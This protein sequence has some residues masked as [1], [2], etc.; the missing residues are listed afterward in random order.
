MSDPVERRGVV[1]GFAAYVLWGLAPLYFPLLEPAGAIEIL[2]HRILWSLVMVG[3]VVSA[4]KR[5]AW[6]RTLGMRK[7]VLLTLAAIAVSVN[8]G[9]YIYAVNEQRVIEVSL[10]Y[11]ILPL[12]YVMS[13]VA[14]YGERPRPA[15]WTGVALGVVAVAILT[16][17]YGQV[18]WV[19]LA[20][21]G[22][23]GGYA[24]IKKRAGVDGPES[25]TIETLV[26]LVPVLG[27][28]LV[29]EAQGE[30]RFGH[31]SIGQDLLFIGCGLVTAVPLLCFSA[32]TVRIPMTVLGML[33]YLA[34]VLQFLIGWL[35]LHEAMPTSRWLG[36]LFIW[37][38]LAVVG[39]DAVRRHASSTPAPP[40]AHRSTIS[41]RPANGDGC[42]PAPRAVP[43]GGRA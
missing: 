37:T 27:Y 7:V 35:L 21:A 1:Y 32:A 9:I 10:G 12:V 14:F 38:A 29:L 6:I 25:V 2:A 23:F 20:I 4:T 8:W 15:Q 31:V 28:L 40:T 42:S 18:P 22:T 16:A 17:D 33:Q 11:F 19:S 30:G 34:P 13:G 36:F 41:N 5:W 24:I 43:P 39:V 26:M 3:A